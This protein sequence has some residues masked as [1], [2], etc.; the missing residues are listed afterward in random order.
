MLDLLTDAGNEI[1]RSNRTKSLSILSLLSVFVCVGLKSEAQKLMISSEEALEDLAIFSEA[2]DHHPGRFIYRSK[3]E[4]DSVKNGLE[5]GITDSISLDE[6]YLKLLEALVFLK[7]G[8][9]G[10]SLGERYGVV[11]RSTTTLPFRYKIVGNEIFIVDTLTPRV[12]D[13]LY[14]KIVSINGVSSD[15]VLKTCFRY[16]TADNDNPTYRK[17]YNERIIGQN[18][19]FFFGPVDTYDIQ[20]ITLDGDTV[21]RTIDGIEDYEL[22][23]NAGTERPLISDFL[24]EHDLAI[25]EVNTFGYRRIME[26]GQDFHDFIDGFFKEVRRKKLG[27]IV[28]DIREN[29]GGSGALAMCLFAYLSPTDFKWTDYSVTC[30]DG[31]EGFAEY[32]QYPDGHYG[33]FDTHDTLRLDNQRIRVTDGI[34][35]KE[36]QS[37]THIPSGPKMKVKDI[38]KNKYYGEVFVLTSGITFSAGAIF[39][40]KCAELENVVVIGEETGSVAGVF[41]GG[42]YLHVTL[43][44]SGFR[45]ELPTMERH[46]ALSKGGIGMPVVPDHL[47]EQKLVDY[48]DGQDPEIRKVYEL[49][50]E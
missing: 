16:T 38:T 44:N 11:K 49:I 50:E 39:A 13:L 3:A 12:S 37:C 48:I 24:Y 33:F 42:G 27:N 2:I 31:T 20:F 23:I 45:I 36:I 6:L 40:S 22:R 1:K 18:V 26:S 41:C 9:T 21:Q 35:S 15:S 43:P 34:E 29:W 5:T 14:A 7:D 47:I 8:H 32:T 46:I 4:I 10:L 25:L 28:I 19:D 30:L 17:R